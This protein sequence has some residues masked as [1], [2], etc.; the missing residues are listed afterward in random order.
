[1]PENKKGCSEHA[2]LN[3]D[4]LKHET[5]SRRIRSKR[6]PGRRGGAKNYCWL[7]TAKCNVQEVWWMDG[8]ISKGQIIENITCLIKEVCFIVWDMRRVKNFEEGKQQSAQK[9]KEKEKVNDPVTS[10][11]MDWKKLG[12]QCISHCNCPKWDDKAYTMNMSGCRWWIGD[13]FGR[14]IN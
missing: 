2:I 5:S 4:F 13:K 11:R 14:K 7:T 9:L 3:C 10:C 1:M 12:S 8:Q 6:V